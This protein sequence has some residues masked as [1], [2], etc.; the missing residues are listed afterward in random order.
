M[1]KIISWK[2]LGRYV[3]I[4]LCFVI[5]ET[6]FR[7]QPEMQSLYVLPSDEVP[8][9][10]D[11]LY[12][13]VFAT[14]IGWIPDSKRS[15]KRILYI[16]VYG[17]WSVFMFSEYIYCR[18]F[19]RVY[20]IKTLKY[21]DEG[22][23]FAGIIFSYF[24]KST[25]LIIGVLV[26]GGIIGYFLLPN[27]PLKVSRIIKRC[28]GIIIV[29]ASFLG[30]LFIPFMFKDS[31]NI[32][33]G[34]ASY[35]YKKVIYEE[36]IDNKRAVSM[37]GAYEFLTR[38]VFL[39]F[40]PDKV[41][42][43]DIQKVAQY[44]SDNEKNNDMTGIFQGKNLIFVLMESMDDWLI[45]E[46]TTPTIC[47]MMDEGINFINMYTPIFGSAGTLNTEFCSYTGFLAPANGNPIVNYANNQYPYSLPHLFLEKGY[48]CKSFHYNSPE[49]YNRQN[50]HHA[51]GFSEY[52]SYLDYEDAEIAE[53]DAT[54]TNNDGIYEKLTENTP[55]FAY[56][57]TYSA[58]STI[59]GKSGYSHDDMA[60][61]IYPEYLNKYESEEMD[62]IS[63][64]A[65]LTD[66]MFAGLLK[67][68]Q[69]DDLLS[70]TVIIAVT[71]HYDYT[72]SDQEYL[73]ELSGCDNIYELSKTPF[74]IWSSDIE[75]REVD[76]VVNTTDLYPTIC[77]LFRLDNHGYFMGDDMFDDTYEGYA[78]WQDGSWINLDG[79]FYSDTG[80]TV[81]SINKDYMAAIQEMISEKI[82][83]NQLVLDTDYFSQ[84]EGTK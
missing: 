1:K 45:N 4:I 57:I 41:S 81:G 73:K 31:E 9:L 23:D 26:L 15:I 75:S 32:E 54:L 22:T 33:T 10:F 2:E 37:F 74:F 13:T 43:E 56:V 36:W 60:L 30:I 70:D 21:A 20:G 78:Y 80:E 67:R 84:I 7:I 51:V 53:R 25:L 24:D 17:F 71:D 12:G 61:E 28:S 63:A 72:I 55:F 76:K 11:I 62:S 59:G 83:I 3:G 48:S 79:A 47:R 49:F 16:A 27:C 35:T 50:I 52:V 39:S 42:E 29:F 58:H 34:M 18:V 64:K 5:A 69:E 19:G 68:L 66:D 65:R 14:L 6:Y 77:N 44:F 46:E 40:F 38:D 8:I 82:K